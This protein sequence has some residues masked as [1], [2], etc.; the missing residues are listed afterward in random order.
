MSLLDEDLKADILKL[1]GDAFKNPKD[2]DEQRKALCKKV[3]A[4]I[5][6]FEAGAYKGAIKKLENE[7]KHKIEKWIKVTHKTDLL[8]KID[9]IIS[10]LETL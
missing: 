10:I 1:P 5:R 9:Q 3:D 2:A 6:Q 8:T 4:V 7:V